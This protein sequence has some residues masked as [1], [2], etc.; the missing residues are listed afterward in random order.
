MVEEEERRLRP[1]GPRP[2][3]HPP[4][5]ALWNRSAIGHGPPG[6]WTRKVL[7]IPPTPHLSHQPALRGL[8]TGKYWWDFPPDS[9][10]VR[11]SWTALQGF[12]ICQ[13]IGAAQHF[14]AGDVGK[15]V[16]MAVDRVSEF[17]ER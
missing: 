15:W 7:E 11:P 5:N 9:R 3:G 14:T 6:R 1:A 12:L 8:D 10:R 16:F 13:S 2:L 17:M 4:Q